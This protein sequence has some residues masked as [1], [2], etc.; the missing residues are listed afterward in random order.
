M[1][2]KLLTIYESTMLDIRDYRLIELNNI[3]I[4]FIDGPKVEILGSD[5]STYD[6]TFKD[7]Y[8]NSIYFD[9]I[10][11]NMWS[12][13][14]KKYFI[15]WTIVIN[16]NNAITTHKYDAKN[17]LI[18]LILDSSSLGDNIAWIPYV[19]EFRKLHNCNVICSTFFNDLFIETYPNIKF[20]SP[21]TIVNNL[22]AK[23]VIGCFTDLNLT[24]KDFRDYS[25]Q[26]MS[27]SIL[28]LPHTEIKPNLFIDKKERLIGEKYVCISTSSTAGCKH[29][30]NRNGWQEIVWY[31]K[32]IGYKV[33]VI[34]KEPLDYMDLTWLND[35]FHPETPNIQDA[36]NWIIH[37]EFF[38][39]ISSG[40]SWVSW[41]LNKKV[42]LISGFTKKEVEFNTQYRILNDS[43][44]NGC[45]NNK[46]HRF[47]PGDWNWC[48]KHKNSERQFECSKSITSDMVIYEI[49]NVINSL[50]VLP[51]YQS[52][53]SQN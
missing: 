7:Q 31:L 46:N 8:G 40:M 49:N 25:L 42:I 16:H 21:G 3:I 26:E 15:D 6:I 36:I 34:Q 9:T 22:Y 44:C 2:E 1:R 28:G 41:A 48:P 37:S 53:Y 11:N 38:I 13:C 33:V 20:V 45:W 23:Y 5:Q 12:K 19:E 39:G 52:K 51:M 27:S 32:S 4:N 47:D 18:Y 50:D 30:Q 35:V 43:V 10:T 17:K 24:P 29:W 14:S